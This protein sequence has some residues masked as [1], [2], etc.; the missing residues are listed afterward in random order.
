MRHEKK[1]LFSCKKNLC[2]KRVC[3]HK[4]IFPLCQKKSF[5]IFF[6][7]FK[8]HGLKNRGLRLSKGENSRTEAVMASKTRGLRPSRG[9]RL[10]IEALT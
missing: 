6:I 1:I 4:K 5:K 9:E 2:K 10:R 7:S 8:P 3:L